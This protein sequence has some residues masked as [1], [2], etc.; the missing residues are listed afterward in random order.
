M[1]DGGPQRASMGT[2]PEER[3]GWL[4]PSTGSTRSPHASFGLRRSFLVAYLIGGERRMLRLMRR[5]GPIMTMPVLSLGDVAIVSD[6]ELVRAGF[7]RSGRRP[8]RGRGCG[9]RC[10]DLR[11]GI[12]VCAGGA[13]APTAAQALD[14]SAA[15]RRA[16]QLCA[17]H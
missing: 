14:A 12:D 10:G 3:T 2:S 15:W 9:P 17:D 7:H 5:Y 6:P 16:E 1:W 8:T 13:G 4:A 11:F